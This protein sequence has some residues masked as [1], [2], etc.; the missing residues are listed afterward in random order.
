M[1]D[2]AVNKYFFVF[3]SILDQYKS[4]EI[5]SIVTSNDHP[6][7]VYCPDKYIIQKM[8]DKVFSEDH[9]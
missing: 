8:C 4:E 3:D 1:C 9:F 2:K 5:S 7:I 6:L